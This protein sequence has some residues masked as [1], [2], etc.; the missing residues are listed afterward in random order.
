MTA[1]QIKSRLRRE[2]KTITQWAAEHGFPRIAVYRVLNGEDKA[3]F[4]RA[5]DIAVKLGMKESNDSSHNGQGQHQRNGRD[6]LPGQ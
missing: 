5:H 1:D 2:R 6:S 3:R 4:G